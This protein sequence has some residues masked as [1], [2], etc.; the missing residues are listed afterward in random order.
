MP[1]AAVELQEF[2]FATT[3]EVQRASI[4]ASEQPDW[5]FLHD[6]ARRAFRL[7]RFQVMNWLLINGVR[8][9]PQLLS[10]Q[11]HPDVPCQYPDQHT[12]IHTDFVDKPNPLES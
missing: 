4:A 9:P 3:M 6:E 8:I 7:H 5:K 1:I 11:T 2:M 10:D 12:R